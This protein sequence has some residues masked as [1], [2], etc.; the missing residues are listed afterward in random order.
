VTV[1]LTLATAANLIVARIG[2]HEE[3]MEKAREQ[4][5]VIPN[6]RRLYAGCGTSM[7]YKPEIAYGRYLSSNTLRVAVEENK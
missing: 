3:F 1:H 2:L 5:W 4:H 7:D 6:G